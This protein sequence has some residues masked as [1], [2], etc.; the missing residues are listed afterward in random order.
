MSPYSYVGL[1]GPLDKRQEEEKYFNR[2]MSAVCDYYEVTEAQIKSKSRGTN[3]KVARHMLIYFIRNNSKMGSIELGKRLKRDHTSV[4]Y[5]NG[6]I[7]NLI[8][9]KDEQ[10]LI[11]IETIQTNMKKFNAPK[12][13]QGFELDKKKRIP[14]QPI[15]K[16]KEQPAFERPPAIYS[17][18]SHEEL[19]NKY[20][21]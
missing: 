15:V 14:R 19:I 1:K 7:K 13:Q 9:I 6:K 2:A 5:A 18:R 10:T 11:D 4:L 12:V 8:S 21:K 20:L 16:E 17:N 3:V